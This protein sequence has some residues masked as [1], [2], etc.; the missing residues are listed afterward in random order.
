MM[1]EK[2]EKVKAVQRIILWVLALF[3]PIL[4]ATIMYP[5]YKVFFD[6][7]IPIFI[8]VLFV[9]F[10]LTFLMLNPRKHHLYYSLFYSISISLSALLMFF[11]H[12]GLEDISRTF[13][14]FH[15]FLLLF[16]FIIICL[17][18]WYK[19]KK[20]RSI[21]PETFN[22]EI[23][24]ESIIQ[25]KSHLFHYFVLV[26]L[27]IFFSNVV[28]DSKN[29]VCNSE[30]V[31]PLVCT[32]DSLR[33]ENNVLK[34]EINLLERDTSEL[35]PEL[36]YFIAR[37]NECDSISNSLNTNERDNYNEENSNNGGTRVSVIGNARSGYLRIS[38]LNYQSLGF[39]LNNGSVINSINEVRQELTRGSF[40]ITLQNGYHV[41]ADR[42]AIEPN[43]FCREGNTIRIEAPILGPTIH[44]VYKIKFTLIQ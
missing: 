28:S 18:L 42:I 22:I 24:R 1:D 15:L 3:G 2:I 7:F 17:I 19:V 25:I 27:S 33:L 35:K 13:R 30:C 6:V 43:N 29:A 36:K 20:T 23:V 32:I 34:K 37:Y 12:A 40:T 44:D 14:E 39:E 31:D 10:V 8:A 41:F 11:N 38:R 9:G 16:V 21:L 4:I 26:V 5:K